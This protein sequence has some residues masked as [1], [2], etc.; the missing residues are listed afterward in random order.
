[1]I[2][3]D[4][5]AN[6]IRN[7]V[8]S[9]NEGFGIANN[10]FTSRYGVFGPNA[11]AAS[12]LYSTSPAAPGSGA[13]TLLSGY[14]T[15]DFSIVSVNN[16]GS[17]NVQSTSPIAPGTISIKSENA[18]EGALA[19]EGMLPFL[20]TVA[21]DGALPTYGAGGVAYRSGEGVAILS[22]N[23]ENNDIFNTE[24]NDNIRETINKQ[25]G[26][27]S[28]SLAGSNEGKNINVPKFGAGNLSKLSGLS[29]DI[30]QCQ[31]SNF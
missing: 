6:W 14:P 24:I 3:Q 21:I 15:L 1:M 9:C 29:K 25:S 11:H 26:S 19:L 13:E 5:L 17:F 30:S 16:G 12:A 7:G 20:S 10:E 8:G 28:R 18:I 31:R 2:F 4:A 23:Y 27:L 22:E